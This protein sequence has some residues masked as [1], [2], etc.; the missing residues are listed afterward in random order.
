LPTPNRRDDGDSRRGRKRHGGRRSRCHGRDLREREA[1]ETEISRRYLVIGG[2][3]KRARG[4]TINAV[5]FEV[6][7]GV[8]H[9]SLLAEQQAK[10]QQESNGAAP[11]SHGRNL[12][13]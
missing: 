6:R 10:G 2:G 12:P 5:A 11:N 7:D 3:D 9:R 8:P 1:L 4:R 13:Q